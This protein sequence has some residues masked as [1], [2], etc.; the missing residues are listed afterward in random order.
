[1][2]T[3]GR[4]SSRAQFLALVSDQ[5][6]PEDKFDV[7]AFLRALGGL[8]LRSAIPTL[9]EFTHGNWSSEPEQESEEGVLIIDV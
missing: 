6:E 8:E 1:M 4:S 2:V 7:W 9:P 5:L 3:Y